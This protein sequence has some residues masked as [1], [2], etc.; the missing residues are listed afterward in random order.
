MSGNNNIQSEEYQGPASYLPSREEVGNKLYGMDE[1]SLSYSRSHQQNDEENQRLE[2][3]SSN[4]EKANTGG[5]SAQQEQ[6]V[7][8][9]GPG[10]G[11]PGGPPKERVGFFHPNISH[12]RFK[13]LLNYLKIWFYLCSLVIVVFSI[14]WGALYD[15]ES[16]LKNLTSL[17]IVEDTRVGDIDGLIGQELTNLMRSPQ[18]NLRA[19]WRIY[20]GDEIY[21]DGLFTRGE[22]ISEKLLEKVHH[23]K[24]WSAVHIYPN[25]TYNQY[26]SYKNAQVDKRPAVEF[27]YESARDITNMKPY[28]VTPF[29]Q[30]E[31]AFQSNYAPVAQQ[32][33]SNLTQDEKLNLINSESITTP[34]NFIFNDYRPYTN[35]TLLAPLQVGL[36]YLI[37]ISFFLFNF[38]VETHKILLPHLKMPQYILY[39]FLGN[40]LS[41]LVLSL[42]I[43]AVSAIFQID[44]TV[45]FGKAGFVV[46][47]FS[48]YLTMSAVGGASENMAMLIFTYNPP[49]VG[50]WL[51]S[52]VILN[53]SPSFSPM[54][55]TSHFYRYGY[56]MPIHS[57]NEITKVIFLDIWKGQLGLY[58]GL[59]VV[60]VVVNALLNPL[61]LKHCGKIMA[62]RAQAA[63][64]AK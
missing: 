19:G 10:P 64:A 48:T 21:Q 51:I 22:N 29:Q 28:V 40:Q 31:E 39:R 46:Y 3:S 7:Q 35:N 1:L 15:R 32:L 24:Y 45:A 54:A 37:I 47:W 6:Q 50:F 38:F 18:F 33:I 58:Y 55:L 59:L 26:Q 53:V 11:G 23:R 16:H 27:I 2:S 25:A 60:W 57:S 61:V 34:P 20:Q 30:L 56:M 44:F 52:W 9:G 14:Y 41:Y 4:D 17:V 36:I 62:K 63:A 5:A 13:L 8:G 43:G 42:F 12:L 49:F